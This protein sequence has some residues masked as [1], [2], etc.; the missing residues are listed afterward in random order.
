MH[1]SPSPSIFAVAHLFVLVLPV[2]SFL[3]LL[4]PPRP[5]LT[6]DILN[7]TSCCSLLDLRPLSP[8][9][10]PFPSLQ[11][12]SSAQKHFSYYLLLLLHLLVRKLCFT[13][14]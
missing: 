4:Q 14:L 12:T 1:L 8:P 10:P 3:L 9:L 2:F 13:A 5:F 6:F 7:L 11:Q